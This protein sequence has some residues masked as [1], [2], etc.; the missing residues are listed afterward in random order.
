MGLENASS[1]VSYSVSL[2]S[3]SLSSFSLELNETFP[4]NCVIFGIVLLLVLA[5][6]SNVLT[7]LAF[8]GFT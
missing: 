7:L 1:S 2:A 5:V 3:V 4:S 8:I 6:F